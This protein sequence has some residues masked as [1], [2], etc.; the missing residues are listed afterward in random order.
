MDDKKTLSLKK[1][2]PQISDELMEELEQL[3]AEK[4][5]REESEMN[6]LK[7]EENASNTVVIDLSGLGGMKDPTITIAGRRFEHGRTYHVDNATKWTLEEQMN[8]LR[9]HEAST[10][11][12]EN[13]GRQKRRA[14]V[15]Q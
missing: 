6:R 2:T 4:A 15:N 11:E 13:K 9:A 5:S 7:A 10:R 14:Y 1:E 3:R 12:S 8:R